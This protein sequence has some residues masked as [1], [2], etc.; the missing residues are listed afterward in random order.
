MLVHSQVPS[1]KVLGTVFR[2]Q[3]AHFTLG[4]KGEIIG[5]KAPVGGEEK[6]RWRERHGK[7]P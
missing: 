3:R 7:H 4:E 2:T 5:A 6:E 1:S